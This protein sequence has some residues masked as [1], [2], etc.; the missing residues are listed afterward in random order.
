[1]GAPARAPLR[2]RAGKPCTARDARGRLAPSSEDGLVTERG[3]ETPQFRAAF[4][5]L[6]RLGWEEKADLSAM[7]FER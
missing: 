7:V 1:M 6:Q 2:S 5:E 4:G 3:F